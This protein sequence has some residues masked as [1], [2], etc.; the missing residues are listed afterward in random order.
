MLGDHMFGG[1]VGR[2]LIV[3]LGRQAAPDERAVYSSDGFYW[4]AA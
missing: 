3:R 2:K 1:I 4:A